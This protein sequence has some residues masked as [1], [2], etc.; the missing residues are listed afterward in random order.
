MSNIVRYANVL[1]RPSL[2]GN[3]VFDSFFNDFLGDEQFPNHLIQSTRGYPVA[4]I[5]KNNEG[6]TV[7]EFALAGF[8]RSELTIDVQPERRSITV[9]AHNSESESGQE[10]RR[11]A[12]RNFTKT[13]VNYDDNLDLARTEARFEN[14]LLTVTVPARPTVQPISI[15]IQ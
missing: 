15:K 1:G 7:M 6:A 3:A 8:S 13:Y 14:G 12:R 4:D 2:L 9:S 11:I 5:Y 10:T